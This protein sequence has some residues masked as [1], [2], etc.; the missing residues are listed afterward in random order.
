MR[1]SDAWSVGGW[2]LELRE[3]GVRRVRVTHVTAV[4]GEP[5]CELWISDDAKLS[6]W[7]GVCTGR[8]RVGNVGQEGGWEREEG[9][10]VVDVGRF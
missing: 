7:I 5:T 9:I 8:K 10:K 6:R 4:G 2:C 3:R 1:G